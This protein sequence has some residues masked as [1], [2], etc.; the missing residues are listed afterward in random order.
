M[1][2][3]VLVEVDGPVATVTLNRPDA[4][5]ALNRE[6]R[7]AIFTTLRDLDARDDLAAIVL[8]GADPAFCAGVDLKELASGVPL[9]DGAGAGGRAAGTVPATC[10]HPSSARST[11]SPSPA[12]SS[13]RSRATSSSRR[14]EPASPTPTLGSGSCPGGGSRCC[15]PRPSGSAAPRSSRP[16]A[17]SST[18]PP[19]CRGGSSTTSCPTR[20]C[21]PFCRQLGHDIATVERRAVRRMLQ[22]YDDGALRDGAGAWALEAEVAGRLAGGRARSRGDR[23]QPPGRGGPRSN[24]ALMRTA[25]TLEELRRAPKVLLHDH[26]DGG[27]RPA[28]VI[29]LAA[30]TATTACPPPTRPS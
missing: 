11:A 10:R 27:L 17:T 20:S 22:T 29:E 13:W 26:L 30:R 19:R 16:P 21:C 3:V 5:N 25:P 1:S 2:D 23:A 12:G 24:P 14:S 28:T 9:G 15:C 7:K 8:T 18:P 4:R 6:L